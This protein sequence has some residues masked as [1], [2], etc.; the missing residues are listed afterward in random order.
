GGLR[1][2]QSAR[3]SPLK[4]RCWQLGWFYQFFSLYC[5]MRV[6]PDRYMKYFAKEPTTEEEQKREAQ[7]YSSL[8]GK[9]MGLAAHGNWRNVNMPAPFDLENNGID[10]PMLHQSHAMEQLGQDTKPF[11]RFKVEDV[12][13]WF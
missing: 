1:T 12:A 5:Y 7:I 9:I 3:S 8:S 2:I 10:L 13:A 6:A 11:D 4:P